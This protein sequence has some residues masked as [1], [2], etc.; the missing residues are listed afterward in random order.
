MATAAFARCRAARVAQAHPVPVVHRVPV[1]AASALVAAVPASIAAVP[2]AVVM[3][4]VRRAP[5]RAQ[6][7]PPCDLPAL[8]RFRRRSWSKISPSC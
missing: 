3:A 7:W 5:P 4:E 8:S 6:L 2:V 1:V